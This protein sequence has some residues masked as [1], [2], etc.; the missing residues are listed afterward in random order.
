M[1][2]LMRS[3][4]AA[5]NGT[6]GLWMAVDTT[7][8]ANMLEVL[9]DIR[10]I[11]PEIMAQ[12]PPGLHGEVI[13]DASRFVEAAIKEVVRSLLESMLNVQATFRFFTFVRLIWFSGL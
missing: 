11:L 6:L 8:T 12:L 1:R 5:T 13:N 7:P 9:K 2:T 3:P 4:A 10:K